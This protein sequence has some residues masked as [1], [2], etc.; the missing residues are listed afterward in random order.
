M[1][2]FSLKLISIA[3]LIASLGLS[4]ISF[5][6]DIQQPNWNNM[7]NQYKKFLQNLQ[8]IKNNILKNNIHFPTSVSPDSN[9]ASSDNIEDTQNNQARTATSISNYHIILGKRRD[10]VNQTS[11]A[12]M[13]IPTAANTTQGAAL[14]G[15]DAPDQNLSQN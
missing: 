6:R 10:G 4:N 5:A 1:R 3:L 2:L 13:Y 9:G 12:K 7:N 15:D 14:S 8:N 11:N